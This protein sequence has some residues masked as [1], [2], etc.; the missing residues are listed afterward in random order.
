MCNNFEISLVVF[1]TTNHA[2]TYTNNRDTTE[3]KKR[4]LSPENVPSKTMLKNQLIT[5]PLK[6]NPLNYFL[7]FD[8]QTADKRHYYSFLSWRVILHL[9][10]AN[11]R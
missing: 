2:I 3:A 7:K 10:C 4:I 6:T 5:K 1:V 11:T 9:R 8:L